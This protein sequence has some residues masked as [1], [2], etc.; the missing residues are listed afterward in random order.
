MGIFSLNKQRVRYT[1][2]HYPS[3]ES[4]VSPLQPPVSPAS[5]TRKY[6]KGRKGPMLREHT[7]LTFT[8]KISSPTTQIS[9]GYRDILQN[10]SST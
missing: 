9:S 10:P 4:V 1:I 8:Q 6:Y 2:P 5:A 7:S 3:G